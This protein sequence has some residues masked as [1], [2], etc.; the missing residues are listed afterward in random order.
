MSLSREQCNELRGLAIIF[1][2]IHNFVHQ[3]RF[4][5]TCQNES[6]FLIERTR[7]YLDRVFSGGI[8]NS[9]YEFFSFLG[10]IGVPVFVF[11]SGYGLVKKYETDSHS[12]IIKTY[13]G[14]SW[15]KLFFLM[16]PG[17][18]FFALF[19]QF[20]GL[21]GLHVHLKYAAYLSLLG[22]LFGLDTLTP[23]I[24]WYFGLTFELYL[25]YIV[26]NRFR[27]KTLLF[28][29][30]ALP[31]V[32]Q[33]CLL[34]TGHDDFV[35]FNLRNLIGWLPVFCTGVY[36][37]RY[38]EQQKDHHNKTHWS[39]FLGLLILSA[40]LLPL[41]NLAPWSWVFIHFVSL[42][43]FFCLVR[44]LDSVRPIASA[45]VFLGSY[46]SFVFAS[47]PISRIIVN[48]WSNPSWGVGLQLM[49]YF[50]LIFAMVPLY[51]FI[52]VK[53]T[54]LFNTIPVFKGDKKTV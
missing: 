11:L 29:C 5:F 3:V 4:G 23:S 49:L 10:W 36:L 40:G 21:G 47:H 25:A 17:V 51:K 44:L 42:L 54:A 38:G 33:I 34:Y 9:V 50:L 6:S 39:I 37:G 13:V 12:L 14:H 18:V 15:L 52:V 41:C 43:F 45:L 35:H 26:L 8:L 7:D 28:C 19:N 48:D 22:N 1:I 53:L 32:F 20:I 30:V 46:S 16:L 31:L 27:S 2:V 24:Y